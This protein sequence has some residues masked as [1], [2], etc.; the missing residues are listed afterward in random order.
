MG[1]VPGPT[2]GSSIGDALGDVGE[3]IFG[4]GN[5]KSGG[6]FDSLFGGIGKLLSNVFVLAIVIILILVGVVGVTLGTLLTKWY[7]WAFI[8]IVYMMKRDRY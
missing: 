8:F 7:F 2:Y 3:A 5:G 4:G 1:N 6:F